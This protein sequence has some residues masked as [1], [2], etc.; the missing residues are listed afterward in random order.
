MKAI[1][2]LVLTFQLRSA[3]HKISRTD[4]KKFDKQDRENFKEL[5]KLFRLATYNISVAYAGSSD[6]G[7][8]A[9]FY[10]TFF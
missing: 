6:E 10:P 4:G 5:Y 1:M 7:K 8:T 2:T 9:H 3:A